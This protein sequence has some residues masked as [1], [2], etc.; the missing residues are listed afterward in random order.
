MGHYRLYKL[1]PL[2]SILAGHSHV[3]GSDA[4]ALRAAAHRQADWRAA[5]EVWEGTRRVARLD[6]VTPWNRIRSQW[7]GQPVAASLNRKTTT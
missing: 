4:E 7:T 5:V 6:P 2:G 3:C 1:D